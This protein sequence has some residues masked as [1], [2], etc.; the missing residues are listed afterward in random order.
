MII[1][2]KKQFLFYFLKKQTNKRW[3]CLSQ[4]FGHPSSPTKHNHISKTTGEKICDQM[5]LISLFHQILNKGISVWSMCTLLNMQSAKWK[6]RN[7]KSR[8]KICI[9]YKSV[10]TKVDYFFEG[11]FIINLNTNLSWN[12]LR[13]FVNSN[14]KFK[15]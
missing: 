9:F 11:S 2:F 1:Y 10:E 3:E 6:V 14:D 15:L 5:S 4:Y 7:F 13:W 8:R 12:K